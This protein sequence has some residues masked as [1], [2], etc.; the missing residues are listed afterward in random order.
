[1]NDILTERLSRQVLVFDGAMGTEIYR[2]NFFINTS[3]ESLCLSAPNIIGEIHQS[4]AAAGA[5]VLTTNT[6]SANF[7][8]LSRFGLGDK[9]AEINAAAV[10]LA[11]EYG[12]EKVLVAGSVGPVGEVDLTAGISEERMTEILVE[13][14]RALEAAG[15]DF[16]IFESL[17]SASDTARAA[18]AANAAKGIHYILSFTLDRNAET[19]CGENIDV[20]MKVV[21]EIS[22]RKPSALGLNCGEGPEST[23]AAFEKIARKAT[24]PMVVQPNAGIPKKIDNRMI[25]MTSPEYFT[26]YSLRYVNLGARG[27]GGCCGISPD[28]IRDM[29]RSIRPLAASE[30]KPELNIKINEE[31][32]LPPVPTADKSAFA[33]K[34]ARGE[35]VA[36]IE[37]TPPRGFDLNATIAKAK[38]CREAGIDAINLPDGPRASSRISPI[39]TAIEIQEKAGIEAILHFCCRDKSLIGMQADILG[40]ACKN[41]NNMLFI[42]GDPPKLGD[43][44]FSSGVFD[45]D[46]IGMVKLQSRLN[47]GID[48]GGKPLGAQTRVLIGVGAD[49]NAIDP[50]R[51]YRRTCEKVE[52]GAEYI[53]TQPVFAAES[54]LKFVKR[55][56]HLKTPVIA[57]I[58]PLASYR[59]AE[60]MRN[61]V[62]GVVVPDE[63]MTRMAKYEDKDEQR[64]EG[65]RIA[66]ECVDQIRAHVQGIQVSAPFGNVDTAIAVIK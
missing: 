28:H 54:L 15:A 7:N 36:T 4:Y 8:K 47:R 13:Q 9:V 60:F 61:E 2:H 22:G 57:G 33:A 26:T 46:S 42:T 58:W 53:I 38:K 17:G 30:F 65:I 59:N 23:F 32:T 39:I 6:F 63:I 31:E 20:L 44:P 43:Y 52:S 49:P 34:L 29:S 12:G 14:V 45:V 66:R 5:D 56:A 55:I 40:C 10:R 48:F 41:I 24:Y 51:E 25:Y 18:A 11:R 35:W 1:M 37:I 64:A 19:S 3:F 21:S 16:I 27:V 50:E 62:P